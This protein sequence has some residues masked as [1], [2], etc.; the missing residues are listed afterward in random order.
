MSTAFI[1]EEVTLAHAVFVRQAC[2]FASIA[3]LLFETCQ[4]ADLE[5]AYLWAR[6]RVRFIL[7]FVTIRHVQ[8]AS[9]ILNAISTAN[10]L[11]SPSPESA[12]IQD[13]DKLLRALTS[14]T[15]VNLV[16]AITTIIPYF[17]W[18]VF[19]AWR[20]YALS[21]HNL[22]VTL[23][24]LICSASFAS[25][26]LLEIIATTNIYTANP[27]TLVEVS[28]GTALLA[29]IIVLALTCKKTHSAWLS[30]KNAGRLRSLPEVLYENGFICFS[31]VTILHIVSLIFAV[32]PA[33]SS[34]ADT[35]ATV[36]VVRDAVITVVL[37]RFILE[38]AKL[39]SRTSDIEQGEHAPKGV[40]TTEWTQYI[41]DIPSQWTL[42]DEY[43]GRGFDKDVDREFH[44]R[45]FDR[46]A[47]DIET[48]ELKERYEAWSAGAMSSMTE[49]V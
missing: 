18:A 44:A 27:P 20:A 37:S 10:S 5:I 13:I 49:T 14:C 21:N 34:Q 28:R 24:V 12:S 38:L 15:T 11:G 40:L 6:G 31:V 46:E 7:L 25:P 19:L 16:G 2:M 23:L 30:S 26:S 39:G 35:F 43:N 47:S 9:L 48:F 17:G 36:A 8:L 45:E 22:Y 1:D 32:V 4:T 33:L 42:D 29:E 41:S 3:L